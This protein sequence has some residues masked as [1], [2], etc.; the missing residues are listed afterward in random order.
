MNIKLRQYRNQIGL[1]QQELVDGSV[2]LVE[3]AE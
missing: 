1:T 2:E 3:K